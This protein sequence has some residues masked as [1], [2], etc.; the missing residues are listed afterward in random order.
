MKVQ[1]KERKEK[2]EQLEEPMDLDTEEL[3]DGVEELD[4]KEGEPITKILT[5]IPPWK[6]KV[7]VTKDPNLG[8]FKISMSLLLEEVVFEGVILTRIPMLKL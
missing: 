8:K 7:K 4:A 1:Q 2:G 5:Y 6:G 3:R